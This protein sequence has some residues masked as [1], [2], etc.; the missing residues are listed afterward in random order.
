MIFMEV[1]FL[2]T[3]PKAQ[4]HFECII[5]ECLFPRT[6]ASSLKVRFITLGKNTGKT[7]FMLR[8]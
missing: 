8:K 7:G 3:S 4:R 1:H 2:D 5:P 6:C